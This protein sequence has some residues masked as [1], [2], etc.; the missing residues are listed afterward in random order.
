MEEKFI[1]NN[2]NNKFSSSAEENDYINLI[3]RL[4]EL[5]ISYNMG[6]LLSRFNLKAVNDIQ[7]YYSIQNLWTNTDYSGSDPEV[8]WS[9]AKAIDRGQDFLTAQHPRV[10][11]WGLTITF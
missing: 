2:E 10:H 3:S 7:I 5:S 11:T 1:S 6:D 8:N 4:K 9:G